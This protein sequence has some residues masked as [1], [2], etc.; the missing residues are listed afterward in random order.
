MI[1][2]TRD[3][4]L[5]IFACVW[6]VTTLITVWRTGGVPNELLAALG[7]GVGSILAAFRADEAVARRRSAAQ[8]NDSPTPNTREDNAP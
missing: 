2:D 5:I 4:L 6:A 3:L 8:T 7:V 1:R